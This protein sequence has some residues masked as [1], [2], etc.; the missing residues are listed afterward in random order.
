MDLKKNYWLNYLSDYYY[1][2][3]DSNSCAQ[4]IYMYFTLR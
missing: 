2:I 3:E 4:H 1:V